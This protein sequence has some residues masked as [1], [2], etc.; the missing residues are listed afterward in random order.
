LDAVLPRIHGLGKKAAELEP[1]AIPSICVAMLVAAMS[2]IRIQHYGPARLPT[3]AI[4]SLDDGADHRLFCENFTWCSV[5]LAYPTLH[6]FIDGRC[7]AYPLAIWHQYI[8]TIEVGS[9]WGRPLGVY[10]VDT[11]VAQRGSRFAIALAE[12]ADWRR[13]FE[14]RAYVIFRHE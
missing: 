11:V 9:S 3:A 1:V 10:R 4:A 14:D 7:D 2:L 6:V 5:A 12:N 8:S 13:A